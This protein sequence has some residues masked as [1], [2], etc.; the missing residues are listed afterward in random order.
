MII[1]IGISPCPNDTYIFDAIYHRHIKDN[2]YDFEF[3]FEDVETLNKMALNAELDMV[4]ISIA[5]YHQIAKSYQLMKTGNALGTDVGPL[6]IAKE[7]FPTTELA[8][9]KIAVPGLHTTA[10][11]LLKNAFPEVR[12]IKEYPFHEIE[13]AI[14]NTEVDCGV[15]IHENRFTYEKKGLV[16]IEDLGELWGRK[17]DLP[18]PLGGIAI[19]RSFSK[20]DILKINEMIKKAIFHSN[21]RFP[22]IS[23]FVRNH[24]QDMQD[25]VIHQ[26]INLYVNKHTM[27]LK[28][29]GKQAIETMINESSPI[30]IEAIF[31]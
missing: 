19:K 16:K 21:T 31:G 15:I 5:N 30:P 1:K 4:K 29:K 22:N 9:K 23:P 11:F 26:H 7:A 17:Y 27:D 10:Y 20:L 3:I 2:N 14:L 25:E 12:D 8:H 6:I 28:A 24:A 13:Q 18:V